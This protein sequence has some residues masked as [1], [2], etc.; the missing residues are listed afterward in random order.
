MTQ[1]T[2]APPAQQSELRFVP[3]TV[4][5]ETAEAW[6]VV[7]EVPGAQDDAADVTLEPEQLTIN[8]RVQPTQLPGFELTRHG[9]REGDYHQILKLPQNI[10]RQGV[11]AT[12]RQG[13]LR[14]HLPKLATA[15]SRKVSV[16]CGPPA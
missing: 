3:G 6:E 15:Q 16:V 7:C 13:V 12:L 11:T 1:C 10:D 9:F 4:V 8:V 2:A 5:H 14:L